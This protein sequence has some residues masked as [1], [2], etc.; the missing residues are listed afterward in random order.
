MSLSAQPNRPVDLHLRVSDRDGART[1]AVSHRWSSSK[2][3]S[4]AQSEI[5]SS[6]V[7]E[8]LALSEISCSIAPSLDYL[9]KLMK[10]III[11]FE[12]A[13]LKAVESVEHLPEYVG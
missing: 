5:V 1:L 11:D 12:F 3:S 9:T 6:I 8:Q 2:S 7:T 10:A 13:S 4:K